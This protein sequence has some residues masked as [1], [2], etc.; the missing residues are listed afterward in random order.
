VSFTGLPH[1]D[2]LARRL[3]AIRRTSL[4]S[5]APSPERATVAEPAESSAPP[6]LT[7]T[8]ATRSEGRSASTRP[9]ACALLWVGMTTDTARRFPHHHHGDEARRPASNPSMPQARPARPT[10]SPSD[11][12]TGTSSSQIHH[13]PHSETQR[14][15]RNRNATKAAGRVSRPITSRIPSEI[16]VAACIGATMAA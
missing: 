6:S 7:M 3:A 2:D 13:V 12:S 15:V 14:L 4:P 5:S 9:M 16:S 11:A 1:K 8:S 10:A